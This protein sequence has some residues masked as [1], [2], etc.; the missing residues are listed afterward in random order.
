MLSGLQYKLL[1]EFSEVNAENKGIG[2]SV[3]HIKSCALYT[4]IS[5]GVTVE[6]RAQTNKG[7]TQR[8]HKCQTKKSCFRHF[9][10]VI[11][12]LNKFTN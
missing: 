4:F 1:N 12:G 6:L 9:C 8:D 10:I 2:V 3:L 7:L 11:R 5:S